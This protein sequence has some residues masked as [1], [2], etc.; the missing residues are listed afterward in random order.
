MYLSRKTELMH[1]RLFY[2]IVFVN[3]KYHS[4]NWLIQKNN[5]TIVSDP[6]GPVV[7]GLPVY[8]L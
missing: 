1:I 6:G 2:S 7:F 3:Y 4:N 5:M 8:C